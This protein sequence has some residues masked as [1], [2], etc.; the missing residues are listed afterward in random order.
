MYLPLDDNSKRRLTERGDIA[1]AI[2]ILTAEGYTTD[3]LLGEMTKLFYIDLDAFN[4][5]LSRGQ[6]LQLQKLQF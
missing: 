5:V 4:D 3:E 1:A 2:D 6:K